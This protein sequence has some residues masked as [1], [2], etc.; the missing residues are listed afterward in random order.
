M[1]VGMKKNKN[2]GK[3]KVVASLEIGGIITGVILV[4]IYLIFTLS[5]MLTIGFLIYFIV[6]NDND[7]L[8]IS[9]TFFIFMLLFLLVVILQQWQARR[10][11]LWTQDAVALTA[12]SST[13]GNSYAYTMVFPMKTKKILVQ[14]EYN[15]RIIRKESGSEHKSRQNNLNGYARLFKKYADREI[16]ILYS[17]KYDQVLILKD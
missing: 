7:A 1:V 4:I 6:S 14:F 17:P 12:K 10:V 5:L 3:D 8:I 13:I 2:K 16:S 15:G 11:K 9:I